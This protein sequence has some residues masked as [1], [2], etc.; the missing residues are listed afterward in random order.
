MSAD[1][2][3]PGAVPSSGGISSNPDP[4]VKPTATA[5][6]DDWQIKASQ[7]SR[8]AVDPLLGC[9]MGLVRYFGRSLSSSVLVSGLPLEDNRLTPTLFIRAADRAGLSARLVSRPLKE[10]PAH[11]LPVVLLL[12]GRTACLLLRLDGKGAEVMIPESGGGA[13]RMTLPELEAI[14]GGHALFV[15]PRVHFREIEDEQAVKRYGS[16]FWDTLMKFRSVYRQVA[17]AALVVNLFSI[18]GPLFT[19][20]VYDRVVPNNA[21]ETLWVLAIGIGI[22][23]G[24]DL[25]LKILRAYLI[26]HAGKRA[27]VLMSARIFEQAMNVRMQARPGSAGVFANRI[28]EFEIV[29]DFFTSATV[30]AVVDLPFI[31]FFIAVIASIGGWVAIVPTAAVPLVIGVGL[32]MQVPLKRAVQQSNE[33]SAQKHGVL[34]EVIS[35]LDT[36]KSLGAESKMQHEWESFV[37]TSARTSSHVKFL[38]GLGVHF[39]V[40]VQQ[41]VTV[42]AVIV[43]VYQIAQNNLTV[44]GLIACTILTGRVMAPLG[45]IAGLL[46]R[47]N[48]ALSA[49]RSID[50]IMKLPVDRPPGAQYLSRPE[51]SGDIEFKHVTFHYP[52]SEVAA[53]RDISFHIRPGEKV[54]VMGPVGSGK[55]TLARMMVRLYDPEDGEILVDGTDIRQIDPADVRHSIGAVLQDTVLFHGTVRENIAIASP[56]ATDEMILRVAK[57]AGV[58][59]FVGRHPQGYDWRVGERGQMLSGGQRQC[60]AVARALLPDPPILVLDEPTSMMDMPAEQALLQRFNVELRNKTVI[61]ITHRPSLLN[62]VSRVI[63]MGMGAIV[64]DGPRDEILALARHPARA[65]VRKAPTTTSV[66]I[67][68]AGPAASAPAAKP[69]APA[70]APTVTTRTAASPSAPKPDRNP[71]GGR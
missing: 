70:A 13:S 55:S 37:G 11:T 9:L 26:D 60:I 38:S 12:K 34:I 33:E 31:F 56:E 27:D 65:A 51:L 39:S 63:V 2:P 57:I 30:T 16:W 58:H 19:M 29:R 18:A 4:A 1:D 61:L 44:G 40:Y 8:E 42:V 32:I 23:Y 53:L 5:A 52:G 50:E 59:D 45:A 46:S 21:M 68:A 20:N 36:V 7:I 67:P 17:L 14:Y 41:M 25:L 35:A 24:F 3:K 49:R 64:A 66:P 15:R 48:Q 43:G 6:P 22:V 62:M 28:K 47:L 10:I 54:A 69:A 71:A